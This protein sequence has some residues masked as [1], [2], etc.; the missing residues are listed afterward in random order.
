MIK[1]TWLLL[2]VLF[3]QLGFTQNLDPLRTIDYKK[4]EAWVDSIMSQMTLDEK[5]GQIFM[6]AAYSNKNEKHTKEILELIDKYHIGALIFFQDDPVKQVQLTNRYQDSSKVPML[7]GIDGEWGLNMRLKNTYK[8]PWNM[9]LGAVQDNELVEVLGEQIG[10]QCNRMGIHM[11]FAPVVDVNTNPDNPIIGNRSYGESYTNVA[12]KAVAFTSGMQGKFVLASAKHFPGH[13]D[14]ATDSHLTL[15]TV[16]FSK[17]RLEAIELYPYRKT[18][19]AGLGAVMVA[20][21]S[22]PSLEPDVK[23]PSS[24]SPN[25]VTG[26]LKQE[27]GFNGLI[28]SDALNM[29]GSANYSSSAEVNLAAFIA[30]N[31][32]L[33]VPLDIPETVDLFKTAIARGDLPLYR[34][35]ESVEKILRTKYWAGL[36]NYKPI[37]EE[38]LIADLNLV[39]NKVLHSKLVDASITLVKNDHGILPIQ[40]LEQKIAYL[41]IG[42]APSQPFMD[43]LNS[44]TQVDTLNYQSKDINQKLKTYDLLI[45]GFHKSNKNPWKSYKFHPDEVKLIQELSKENKVVLNVFTSPYSLLQ[46]PK[47]DNIEAVVVSYQNSLLA[48]DLSAQKIFGASPYKGKLPVSIHNQFKVGEGLM[49]PSIKRLGYSFPE[50]VGIDSQK[51]YKV[52]SL[53]EI[54]IDSHMAPGGQVLIAKNGKIVFDKSYGYYTY[55][56]KQKVTNQSIYDLASLTK[57][58]GGM[59]MIMKSEEEGKYDLDDKLGDILPYLK[60]SDKEDITIKE[61]LTHYG[62]IY[63]WIAFYKETLDSVSGKPLRSIYRTKPSDSFSVRVSKNLYMK[64]TYVDTIYKR[65]KGSEL[66]EPDTYKYS[67]LIFLLFKKYM[68]DTYHQDLD[69]LNDSLFYKPIGTHLTYHPLNHFPKKI[70]VASEIDTYYRNDT[71]KGYVHDMAAAMLGGVSGNA[72]LFGNSEDV[73]KMMQ[74]YLQE[75]YYAG[76]Q[77]LDSLTFEKFNH[78][79]FEEEHVR[80]GLGFDKP[81]LDPEVLNTCGCVSDLSFGHSGFTGTYAWADPKT[82]LIYVFLS[83]RTYPTMDNNMLGKKDVRTNIQQYIVDAL[84]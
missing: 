62:R 63:P 7:I 76:Q 33:D 57:I 55:S 84:Q 30:G 38:N 77:L 21:L 11:N 23:L 36:N 40:N 71:I 12:E 75:G 20:H 18:F 42:D 13:G 80:R 31:D 67:G 66:L 10:E 81:Q 83:N 72:G 5:I 47:F 37:P 28:I 39:E 61:A 82:Q 6:V 41:S 68:V 17:E 35:N 8:Y 59:P 29:K 65:I 78:R 26:L 19:D 54:V 52:D 50:E 9:T 25:V 70:I 45:L 79:Y 15:P 46:I 64:N 4:Q 56:K 3:Y 32:L 69:Q 53:M 43:R 48:Q 74:M 60:G 14:T 34:L 58:L 16:S 27:M 22:I 2:L 73:A 51:L 44:F 49:L 1:K 24:L